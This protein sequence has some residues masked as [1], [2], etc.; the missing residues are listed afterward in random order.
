MLNTAFPASSTRRSAGRVCCK[1]PDRGEGSHFLAFAEIVRD[2]HG[3]CQS[4]A[5]AAPRRAEPSAAHRCQLRPG[6]LLLGINIPGH[7]NCRAPFSRSIA[8]RLAL[9]DRG[10]A[11][12]RLVRTDRHEDRDFRQGRAAAAARRSSASDRRQCGTRLDGAVHQQ[13]A[14]SHDCCGCTDL[15][16]AD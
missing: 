8:G 6:L 12:A 13:W 7:P 11:H 1:N 5:N 4:I 10:G 16:G 2:P 15:G 9:P 14:G 3:Y